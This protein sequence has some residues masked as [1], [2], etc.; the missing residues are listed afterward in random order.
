MIKIDFE[1]ETEK[2]GVYRDALYLP[3]DHQHTDEE[4]EAMK[5]ERFNN[6]LNIVNPPASDEPIVPEEPLTPAQ[7]ITIAGVEYALLDGTPQSGQSLVEVNG[8]WYYKV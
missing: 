5:Q 8:S 2:Y 6:W 1:F 4:L 3:E 7:S